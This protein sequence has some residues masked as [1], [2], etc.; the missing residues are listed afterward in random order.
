[1]AYNIHLTSYLSNSN[2]NPR[3]LQNSKRL[4]EYFTKLIKF[5]SKYAIIDDFQLLLLHV[6]LFSRCLSQAICEETEK[7]NC[8]FDA[9]SFV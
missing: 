1:M 3:Q 8:L 7:T 5:N 6:I 4:N 9:T 2:L